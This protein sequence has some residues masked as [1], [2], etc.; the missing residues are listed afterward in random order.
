M[1]RPSAQPV[2]AG[3]TTVTAYLIVADADRMLTFLEQAFDAKTG[4]ITRGKD[5]EI[6]HAEISVGTSKLMLGQTPEGWPPR[7]AM[8][9]LYVEDCDAVYGKALAAGAKSLSAPEDQFYGDRSGGVEDFAGNYW[10]IGTHK[11]DLSEAEIQRRMMS[12][13]AKSDR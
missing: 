1:T 8:F 2:P 3:Y 10:Y 11:E 6:R 5:G 13:Q 7:P 12:H 4:H 9:Y